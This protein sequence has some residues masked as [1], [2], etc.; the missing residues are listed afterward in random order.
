MAEQSRTFD[1]RRRALLEST[2]TWSPLDEVAEAVAEAS[3]KE[4]R[5]Y[6]ERRGHQWR[7]SPTSRGGPYPL[8]RITARFLRVD[9]HR[10]VL[11]YRSVDGWYILC[12]DPDGPHDRPDRWGI[13][14]L[15]GTLTP[16]EATA[17]LLSALAES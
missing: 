6:V 12:D 11:P 5:V 8:L 13:V 9:Y 2:R 10:I 14:S 17:A 15:D 16:T 1:P 4:T 7:W 3:A